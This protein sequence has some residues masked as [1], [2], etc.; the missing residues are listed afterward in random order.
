MGRLLVQAGGAEGRS[1]TAGIPGAER[2]LTRGAR[3][4]AGKQGNQRGGDR[5]RH[6]GKKRVGGAVGTGLSNTEERI[7][8]ARAGAWIGLW[9]GGDAS[10]AGDFPAHPSVRPGNTRKASKGYMHCDP[11]ACFSFKKLRTAPSRALSLP[12][13]RPEVEVP[14]ATH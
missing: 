9:W 6:T 2:T 4:E 13:E 8:R 3:Q 5:L 12:A 14:R 7:G 10:S 1:R 11:A